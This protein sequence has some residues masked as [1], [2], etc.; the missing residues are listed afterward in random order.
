MVNRLAHGNLDFPKCSLQM[1]TIWV[2]IKKQ[3]LLLIFSKIRI[4][5]ESKN[6]SVIIVGFKSCVC[7][8]YRTPVV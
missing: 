1:V 4:T 7:G 2:N 8:I 6:Y 5:V 3:S